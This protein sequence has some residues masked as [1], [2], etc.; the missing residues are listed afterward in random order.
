MAVRNTK[1][2]EEVKSKISSETPN[3]RVDVLQLDL[4]SLD[5]V[6]K[7]AKE[8]QSRQLPLNVLM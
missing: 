1:T 3:A 4:A 5:S 2:G 7:F 6:R 8:F